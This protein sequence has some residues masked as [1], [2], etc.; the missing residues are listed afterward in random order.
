M[1]PQVWR[2]GAPIRLLMLVAAFAP[3]AFLMTMSAHPV[4]AAAPVR[5]GALTG[6]EEILCLLGEL[7]A[8]VEEANP[9][10][11]AAG[12]LRELDRAEAIYDPT[13]PTDRHR[14]RRALRH[15]VRQLRSLRANQV[16]EPGDRIDWMTAA[17]AIRGL[18]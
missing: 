3:Q 5:C 4:H 13:S 1:M 12:L 11:F 7:R 9:P 8:Q 6:P 10:Q 2:A 14:A 16:L 15:F 17:L 18:I